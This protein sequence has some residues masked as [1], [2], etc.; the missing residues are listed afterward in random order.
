[1][2]QKTSFKERL[3]EA[4]L[5]LLIS[6]VL[7]AVGFG[8]VS[9]FGGVGWELDFE[10]L[11]LIGCAVIFALALIVWLIFSIIKKNKSKDTKNDAS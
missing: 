2:K 5:E 1:M 7:F 11:A 10:L 4:L 3:I 6:V 8:L 9:L